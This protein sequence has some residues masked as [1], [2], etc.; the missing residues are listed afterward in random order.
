MSLSNKRMPNV[1][2]PSMNRI[3]KQIYD[4][5][6]NIIQSV[7]KISTDADKSSSGK[8]GDIKVVKKS[9]GGHEIEARTK[10]GWAGVNL[11][12]KES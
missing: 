4:D 1:E 6:N 3:V 2:D 8:P 11:T 10:E 9:S 7:N 12:L 5:I